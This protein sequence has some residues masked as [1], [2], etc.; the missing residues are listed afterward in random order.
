M[1]CF[2]EIL[3]GFHFTFIELYLYF[4]EYDSVGRPSKYSLCVEPV[5]PYVRHGLLYDRGDDVTI[6]FLNT[7]NIKYYI[8][9]LGFTF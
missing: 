7:A 8:K 9:G 2:K 3:V 4:F 6:V 5:F 1:V